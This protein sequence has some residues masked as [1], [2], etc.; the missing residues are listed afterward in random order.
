MQIKKRTRVN[1]YSESSR[2][3]FAKDK[4]R[5]TLRISEN[6]GNLS[7]FDIEAPISEVIYFVSLMLAS[8]I[9]MNKKEFRCN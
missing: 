5:P 3:L 7:L 4:F 8:V 9:S 1:S 2:E 6:K